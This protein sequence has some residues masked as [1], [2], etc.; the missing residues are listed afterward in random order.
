MG[1][2]LNECSVWMGSK[3]KALESDLPFEFVLERLRTC[4]FPLCADGDALRLHFVRECEV[5]LLC[6]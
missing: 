3:E 4:R 6:D 2:G 5:V 1:H